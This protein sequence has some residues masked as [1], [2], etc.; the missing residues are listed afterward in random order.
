VKEG[1]GDGG[2]GAVCEGEDGERR[3]GRESGGE[4]GAEIMGEA[5][6]EADRK[7]GWD[8]AR[9]VVNWEVGG[10]G[11]GGEEVSKG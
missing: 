2:C 1:R 5:G 10:W 8:E 11:S 9:E 3:D 4:R 7:W 6:K